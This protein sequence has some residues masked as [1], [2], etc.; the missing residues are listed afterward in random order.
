MKTFDLIRFCKRHADYLNPYLSTGP[1][2]PDHLE[3][4]ANRFKLVLKQLIKDKGFSTSQ[5]GCVDELPLHLMAALKEKRSQLQSSSN[6]NSS[7]SS[8]TGSSSSGSSNTLIRHCGLKG[9]QAVAILSMT[10]DGQLL[11]P[12]VV[13][14]VSDKSWQSF[15]SEIIGDCLAER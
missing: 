6:S 10:A 12:L 15:S 11:P 9:S 5:I 1:R 3:E 8:T 13:L 14:N 4:R 7:V 2:L